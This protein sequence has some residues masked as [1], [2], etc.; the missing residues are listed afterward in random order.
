[1]RIGVLGINFKSAEIAIRE[2]VSKA[3]QRRLSLFSDVSERFSCVVL[4]TC[5]R[6]EI[7]FSAKNLAEAHSELLNV[8]REEI[9]VAFEHKLYA[10]FG[11]D[12]FLHLAQVTAGLDSVI[13]AESE[14]QRQVKVAYEQTLL[15][16]RLPSC[17]HYLFQKSLKVGKKIRSKLSLTQNQVTIPKILFELSNQMLED[18]AQSPILFIGNSEINRKVIHFF[19]QKGI[20]QI[21]LCTRAPHS[22]LEMAEKEG[23]KLVAWDQLLSWHEYSLVICGSNAPHYIVNRTSGQMQTQLIFDLSVPRNVDP[24]LA[25]DPRLQLFNMEELSGLIQMRQE[26]K[27]AEMER[28]HGMVSGDVQ[29]F[30]IA[31]NEKVN[32][33]IVCA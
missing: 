1:M 15:H 25:R 32:R 22:A 3:C 28:A 18:F 12:C 19:K 27:A 13:V 30:S 23:I 33:V 20:T 24:L 4:S 26:M 8:L 14:I 2:F 5:N 29:Q 31:F 21:S 11:A 17:I 6:T 16:Y 7:Y 9:P 10:Y